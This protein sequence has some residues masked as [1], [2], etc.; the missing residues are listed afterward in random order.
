ME[1]ILPVSR[2]NQGTKGGLPASSISRGTEKECWDRNKYLFLDNKNP[3]GVS[4]VDSVNQ[5][6]GWDQVTVL[7]VLRVAQI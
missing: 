5:T 1:G 2:C 4:K 6:D 3:S 7:G